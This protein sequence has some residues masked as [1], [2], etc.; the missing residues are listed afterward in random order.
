MEEIKMS[1][2]DGT[3][4]KNGDAERSGG[5]GESAPGFEA[6][7][8]MKRLLFGQGKLEHFC[9]CRFTRISRL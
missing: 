4:S 5:I 9:G 8:V 6:A 1:L 2:K 7:N 3:K